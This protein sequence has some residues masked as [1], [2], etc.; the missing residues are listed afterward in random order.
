MYKNIPVMTSY[1]IEVFSQKTKNR[2]MNRILLEDPFDLLF[3]FYL[4]KIVL[5][6]HTLLF[7]IYERVNVFF[8]E[9]NSDISKTDNP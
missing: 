5:V 6:N 4:C 2:I 3:T 7:P 8:I 1:A 9:V